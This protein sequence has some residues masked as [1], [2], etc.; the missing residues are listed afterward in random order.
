MTVVIGQ[1]LPAAYYR[2]AYRPRLQDAGG[3][4]YWSESQKSK[5]QD[6]LTLDIRTTAPAWPRLSRV[7]A[8]VGAAGQTSN[9]RG[10]HGLA[11][12]L[13]ETTDIRDRL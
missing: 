12:L 13:I 10:G 9:P 7:S 2:L 5:R 1:M 3:S 11:A 8:G 4:F 6:Q